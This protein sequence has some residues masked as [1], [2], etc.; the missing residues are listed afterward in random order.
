MKRK[1]LF[2]VMF[3]SLVL[4]LGITSVSVT[5]LTKNKEEVKTAE[6]SSTKSFTGFYKKVTDV[7]SLSN[8]DTV[9]IVSDTGEII[10]DL[11]GNPGFLYTTTDRVH[12]SSD[13]NYVYLDNAYVTPQ[14]VKIHDGNQYSFYGEYNPFSRYSASGYIAY[15]YRGSGIEEGSID[16]V[17]D[18]IGILY[19][20]DGSGLRKTIVPNSSFTLSYHDGFM[21]IL[22]VGVEK[23]L[24]FTAGYS[25]RFYLA[26]GN[27][28]NVNIYKPAYVSKVDVIS[29]LTT[30]EYHQGDKIDLSG[31]TIKVTLIGA[32]QYN[33]L[34]DNDP[35]FFS[36]SEYVYGTGNT[37]NAVTYVDTS[38]DVDI[39]IIPSSVMY[40]RVTQSYNDYR[41][42]YYLATQVGSNKYLFNGYTSDGAQIYPALF[43]TSKGKEYVDVDSNTDLDTKRERAQMEVVKSTTY[44]KLRF[45]NTYYLFVN[46]D[47]SIYYLNKAL[48]IDHDFKPSASLKMMYDSVNN[49]AYVALVENDVV[50]NKVLSYYNNQYKFVEKGT[51]NAG[52]FRLYHIVDPDTIY[53]DINYMRQ[54]MKNVFSLCNDQG[55]TDF[56]VDVNK[57]INRWTNL[58]ASFAGLEIDSQA[59]LANLTY[60]HGLEERDSLE[61]LIDRY[62]YIITKY[63]SLN[64]F[65]G[66]RALAETL[67]PQQSRAITAYLQNS[68]DVYP[69]LIIVVS[70]SAIS[71]V[72]FLLIIKQRKNKSITSK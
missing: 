60:T 30:N 7:S 58:S 59:Y 23:S 66:R 53:A 45:D 15:D 27:W 54:E 70:V 48:D 20:K 8:D 43:Y 72:S 49:Y 12:L 64:D 57:G 21:H 37:K 17:G 1:N 50:T 6:A 51:A 71:L 34:Y 32:T 22:N 13:K 28:S 41:G 10:R 55:E 14:T 35:G 65:M 31:L 16:Y 44:F 39:T 3:V 40:E 36:C 69:V 33:V 47:Y 19:F 42:R 63:R 56:S 62:D 9:L 38:F 67:Q 26:D 24:V 68:S 61:D 25:S 5:S 52:V 2:T 11:G 29:G 46:D 18:N 4:A